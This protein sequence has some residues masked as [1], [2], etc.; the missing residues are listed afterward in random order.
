V[1]AAV[2]FPV[3]RPHLWSIEDP[4][5]Y[6]ARVE[7]LDSGRAGDSEEVT[8]GVRDAHFEPNTGFWLNGKNIKIRGVALH[9]DIG[10]LGM[11]AP[12][13]LWEHRLRAMKVMGANAVRTAHNPVAPEF[14]DLCDRMG[15]VV[16]DEFFDQWTVGKNPYDY[17][18]YFRDWYKRDTIDTV[19]RDRNHPSVIAWSA[20]NEIHDTPQPEIAKPILASLAQ[21]YHDND[22]SR[23][24]TQALFRPNA[25]HD[26]EDGLADLLDVVGQNYRPNELLAAHDAKPSRKILGTEDTHDRAMWLAVRDHPAFSGM[27][28]WAGTDYLGESRHWPLFADASGMNDRT[29]WPKPDSLQRESWW[30]DRPVVHIVRRVAPVPKAPT[31]PGYELEQ[32]RPKQTTFPDWTPKDETR[33]TEHVEVYSNCGEVSLSLN[34][35]TL[36]IEPLSP[37]ASPRVW[38]VSF[39]P[40]TLEARCIDKPGV[41]ETLRT[42]GAAASLRLVQESRLG[43][44]FDDVAMVRLSVVDAQGVPLPGAAVPVT[45][46]AEG[47]GVLLATDNADTTYSTPFTDLQRTTL[48]GRAVAYVRASAG[49]EV[50]LRATAPGL[51]PAELTLQ[52]RETR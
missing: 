25:S 45:F 11:A 26:Y 21:I 47:P 41:A 48:D 22:P 42:A 4:A 38:N 15:I 44:G 24:V 9:S 19:R 39:E 7:I 51:P 18:L 3:N 1:N 16:L 27:F 36:G 32:Y 49:G 50:R 14:L 31:D 20:G 34:G 33:H 23:P 46:A 5:L 29:D 43:T 2:Q 40:G 37:D 35:E 30:S 13:S 10:A 8:F 6:R 52:T 12:L 28:L 17:H